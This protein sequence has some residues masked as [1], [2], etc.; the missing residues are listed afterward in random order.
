MSLCLL[1]IG[2]RHRHLSFDLAYEADSIVRNEKGNVHAHDD[3]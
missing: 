3:E 1:P 2:K